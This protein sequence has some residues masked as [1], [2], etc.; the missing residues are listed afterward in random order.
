MTDH[1]SVPLR[2]P[3]PDRYREFS[4]LGEGS[5]GCVYLAL[6]TEL[7]RRVAAGTHTLTWDGRDAA[8]RHVA[9]G[10]YFC[11]LTTGERSWSRRMV[12]GR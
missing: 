4:R 10:V 12:V 8:D 2:P 6:D 11:R 9:P 7:N 5:M 3:P 1:D